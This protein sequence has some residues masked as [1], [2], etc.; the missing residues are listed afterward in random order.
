MTSRIGRRTL[1]A[2]DA[3]SPLARVATTRTVPRQVT[4]IAP[5][6]AGILGSTAAYYPTAGAL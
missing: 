4:F 6:P 3:Y 5:Q 2:L 1:L